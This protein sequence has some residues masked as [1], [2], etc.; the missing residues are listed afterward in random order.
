MVSWFGKQPGFI[1]IDV[2]S[3]SVKLLQLSADHSHV[4][5]CAR[6]ELPA[7]VSND[8][9]NRAAQLAAAIEKARKQQ[10]FRGRKA[11]L[12]L[13]GSDLYAQNIRVQKTSPAEM[14]KAVRQEAA[15]KLP[16]PLA[17]A[18]MRFVDAGDVRQGDLVKR[19]LILLACHRPV[20]AE[21]LKTIEASGLQP[22]A[23]D[24]EPAALLRCYVKQFRRDA[25]RTQRAMFAH[26]GQ[27]CTVVVI[28]RGE[29][30]LFVK[31]LEIGGRH[32][33]EALA[34]NLKM[35]MAEA[36]S[37]RRNHGDR[38]VEQQDPEIA[39]TVAEA[40]RPVVERLA[41]EL[42]LCTRYHNVTFRGQ[43]LARVVIGGGEAT[44]ELVEALSGRLETKCE[45]GDPL[46]SLDSPAQG[47]RKGQWD[48]AAG[49]ALHDAE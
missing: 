43:A 11:V 24:V 22:A 23:V 3:R 46:R 40:T 44:A 48:I 27:T 26:F 16:F 35:D 45:L 36:T 13:G 5:A 34:R 1:G 30:A 33:D 38:R 10:N 31:Y 20:L 7:D 32:L 29:E 49:L 21:L 37:L 6:Q 28:A 4:V 41:S 25:D 18:E 17:E 39:R 8:P 12:C 42:S 14:E 47:G 19:E 15:G 9:A 2:G